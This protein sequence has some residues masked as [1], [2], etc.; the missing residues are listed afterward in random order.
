MPKCD[1]TKDFDTLVDDFNAATQR[2]ITALVR[3][4]E[5]EAAT[6]KA[7][8]EK[9][10]AEKTEAPEEI[11]E[12]DIFSA[13][14][15]RLFART[16]KDCKFFDRANRELEEMRKELAKASK[17][18]ADAALKNKK[19]TAPTPAPDAEKEN[20]E[21]LKPFTHAAERVEKS[22]EAF[23]LKVRAQL[24]GRKDLG[25]KFSRAANE[26]FIGLKKLDEEV[27]KFA[28]TELKRKP[29]EEKKLEVIPSKFLADFKEI[30]KKNGPD[31]TEP[32]LGK[33]LK[34]AEDRLK[35]IDTNNSFSRVTAVCDAARSVLQEACKLLGKE[36][37]KLVK[38]FKELGAEIE[39]Y[40]NHMFLLSRM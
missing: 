7:A 12:D 30:M 1:F 34:D 35:R 20:A 40:D 13:S 31:E 37:P 36:E 8:N 39:K 28:A 5:K 16:R 10:G 6:V 38:D 29:R 23:S 26:L 17:E 27:D 21:I 19:G 15:E 33:I 25:D 9:E 14:L 24:I 11:D 3:S 18:R 2:A 32:K 4:N 22:L